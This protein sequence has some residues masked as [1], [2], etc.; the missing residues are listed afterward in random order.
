MPKIDPLV[1]GVFGHVF[2]GHAEGEYVDGDGVACGDAGFDEE[3]DFFHVVVGD[4]VAAGGF[5]AAMDH[6]EGASA[7]EAAVIGVGE[8]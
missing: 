4:G 2:L 8:A 7:A 3:V 1:V 6:D 5:A